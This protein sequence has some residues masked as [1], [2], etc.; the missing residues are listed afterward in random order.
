MKKLIHSALCIASLSVTSTA[1][2][3]SL[4]EIYDLAVNN[5]PQLRAAHA[6]F[7]AGQE[8]A[9]IGRAGLLPQ[10]G[11]SAS[12]SEEDTDR[13]STSFIG[14]SAKIVQR[15]DNEIDQTVYAISLTQPLFDVPA[16]YDYKQGKTAS[17]QARYQYSA[18]QQEL[19]LRV[20]TA[21]FDVLRASENLTSAIAEQEA[22]GRQLEQTRQ[23]YEVGLLPITDVHEAQAAFDDAAVNTLVL[24]GVLKVA[25]EG[26]EV[27]TGQPHH[28]LAGLMADFPVTD[29][30]PAGRDEWVTFALENNLQLRV[31][32]LARDGAQTNA[33]ARKYEHLPKVTGSYSYQD[34][35]QDSKFKGQSTDFE[36]GLL[37]GVSNPSSL[38]S[39]GHTVAISLNMP[40][41]TGG[42]T[43]A[44]RRQAYQ[45]YIQ[46]DEQLNAARRNITQQTRSAHLKV[47]TNAARVKAR[48]QAIISARS[49]LE[50][51][52]AGYDVGT[53]NIVDV[54]LAERTL[55]AAQRNYA[56]ARYDYIASSLELKQLAGQLK[57]DDLYQL[58]A[59]L[60]PTIAITPV[61]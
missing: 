17:E 52:R 11:A 34:L 20:S 13:D 27:L 50:A 2:A 26:L 9:N 41:F 14:G 4:T 48:Q 5:D 3:D 61:Q 42:L 33:Q 43:S 30:E 58:N 59:W 21:Y 16:W 44:Q 31:T 28:E 19:I 6:A 15:G 53:R 22:I 49:A 25:F 45:R 12:Y 60:E 40:I 46:A 57:P 39:D 1:L 47:I 51:T 24:R 7:M 18:D 56:N 38:N 32:E 54:L 8:S 55:H 35:D 10:L 29:P 36:S 37:E 23:R